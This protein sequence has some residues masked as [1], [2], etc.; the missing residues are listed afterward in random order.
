V[1]SL[2][3]SDCICPNTNHTSGDG[4]VH[5]NRKYTYHTQHTLSREGRTPPDAYR[6]LLCVPSNILHR[7]GL[8][9]QNKDRRA[10]RRPDASDDASFALCSVRH[11]YS[12]RIDVWNVA[13]LIP[14]QSLFTIL[15]R[16]CTERRNPSP[17][18]QEF[19]HIVIKHC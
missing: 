13:L 5:T 10:D 7:R 3:K 4:F 15:E 18:F 6:D 12:W 1:A 11:T 2:N 16:L 14:S 17:I 8:R 9:H 19:Q